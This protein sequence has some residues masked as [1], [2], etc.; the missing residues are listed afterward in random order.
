MKKSAFIILFYLI[1]LYSF[2]QNVID[3]IAIQDFE[4]APVAPVWN[5]NGVL[6]DTISGYA[7]ATSC[8]PGTPLGING[9]T[10]WHVAAVSGGNLITFDTIAV[11]VGYDSLYVS[12]H[13][14][15]LSLETSTG[16]PDD[17]DYVLVQYSIDSAAY[18]SRVRVRGAVNNNS[19]WPYDAAGQAIVPY[20]PT[21]ESVF[22][23]TNSGLQMTDGISY[24]QISF[25]GNI[26]SLSVQITPRSSSL[27]DSWLIDNLVLTGAIWCSNTTDSITPVV[28][29][30]YTA[31]SGA[32][33]TSSGLYYDTIPNVSGCDSIIAINL[34]IKPMPDTSVTQSG[35]MLTSNAV[36]ALYQWLDCNNALAQ[37]SGETGISF[38][39]A[40][41]F[42]SYA[43][44]VDLNGCVDT[45]TCYVIDQTGVDEWRSDEK[46]LIKIVDFL[47]RETD[48]ISNTPLIYIYSDGTRERVIKFEER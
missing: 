32:I 35:V 3:T 10:A 12:F 47:G 5:Y 33:F 25:P 30:S 9:S 24:V 18:V 6:A 22:Q 28:C 21:T 19:F 37:I 17:L 45:S 38:I 20:L 44:E 8:I 11:P 4:P 1:G 39:P 7:S 29:G 41:L 23:P 27:S 34:T 46:Q 26:S 36:G 14:A 40:D 48:F 16:G 13:L 43:V 2:G 42:G 15:G 31:P